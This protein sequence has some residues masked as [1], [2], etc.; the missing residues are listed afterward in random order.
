MARNMKMELLTFYLI[1][2]QSKNCGH[3]IHVHLYYSWCMT[4]TDIVKRRKTN[5]YEN[6]EKGMIYMKILKKGGVVEKRGE[7]ETKSMPQVP[8]C[9]TSIYW[10]SFC[11]V[12]VHVVFIDLCS[13]SEFV[14]ML[15]KCLFVWWW[16]TP[17]LTIF[18][19]YRVGQF[20]WWRKPEY[21]EKITH[22]SQVTDKTLSHNILHLALVEIRTHNINGDMQGLHR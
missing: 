14:D 20:Y 4:S 1:L 19:L 2:Y 21:T 11:N 15:L 9:H 16:L 10:L 17:L 8:V 6:F 5:D 18:Q 7:E 12:Y 13:L 22:L 3:R